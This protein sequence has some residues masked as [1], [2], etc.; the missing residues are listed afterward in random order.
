MHT[1]ECS[2][3]GAGN[4]HPKVVKNLYG[5]DRDE[6]AQVIANEA[7]AVPDDHSIVMIGHNGPSE[8]GTVKIYC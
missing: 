5:Y 6:Y 3:Q 8:L 4:R 7:L 2:L 1:D